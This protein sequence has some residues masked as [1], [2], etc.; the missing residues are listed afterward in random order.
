MW[1]I[2]TFFRREHKK[3]Q[4]QKL[5]QLACH[6]SE[7]GSHYKIQA[8]PKTQIDELHS[9]GFLLLHHLLQE[10]SPNHCHLCPLPPP[11]LL[12]RRRRRGLV[13]QQWHGGGAP[14]R[15]GA[16]PAWESQ[17]TARQGQE[18]F[19]QDDPGM[20]MITQS[21]LESCLMFLE[22]LVDRHF[23]MIVQSPDGDVIDCVPSHLQPA[24]EHPRLRGQKPEVSGGGGGGGGHGCSCRS[25]G[26]VTWP[27]LTIASLYSP[28]G[29]ACAVASSWSMIDWCTALHCRR[30]P[31]RGRR[32]RRRGGGGGGGV[33]PTAAAAAS[34]GRTTTTTST[35]CGRRGGPP[36][37]R[38]RRGR[39]RWGGRRRPTCC[40]PAPPPPPA[41]GSGW[42]LAAAV[43]A[44]AAR[45]GETP[46]AAA[47]RW[48]P[49]HLTSASAADGFRQAVLPCWSAPAR[50]V[51]MSACHVGPTPADKPCAVHAQKF[52]SFSTTRVKF[53]FCESFERKWFVKQISFF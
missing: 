20:S 29:G 37:R 22:F 38:A 35:G 14:P 24:F 40:E 8:A 2:Q 43:A 9:D 15:R 26:A 46:P 18:S 23:V 6:W 7:I 52:L 4:Q 34:T 48:V 45:R 41:A 51:D 50:Q 28:Y 13:V 5:Q 3:R 10:T 27:D 39:Y 25:S 53:F 47:T 21:W 33:T 42:S 19:R 44:S 16:A 30:R 32:R 11:P 12:L 17:G 36:G 31:Q 1:Q 49:R